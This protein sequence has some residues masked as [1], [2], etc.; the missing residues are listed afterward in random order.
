MAARASAP[1]F[2]GEVPA[3]RPLTIPEHVV[4]LRAFFHKPFETANL[5]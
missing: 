2:P 1:L 3:K 5:R 4:F